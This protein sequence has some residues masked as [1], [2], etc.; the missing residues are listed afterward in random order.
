MGHRDTVTT[1]QLLWPYLSGPKSE[2][3]LRAA[4][5]VDGGKTKT[6]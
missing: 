3:F 6:A 2:Q 4:E 5:E 1:M